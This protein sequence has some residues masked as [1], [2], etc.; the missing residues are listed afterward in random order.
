[1]QLESR[2]IE[3][4]VLNPEVNISE[5]LFDVEIIPRSTIFG[6]LHAVS[7]R[8]LLQLLVQRPISAYIRRILILKLFIEL[9]LQCAKLYLIKLCYN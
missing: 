7:Q 5:G 9:V 8:G 1:M 6:A 4:L 2:L 3:H